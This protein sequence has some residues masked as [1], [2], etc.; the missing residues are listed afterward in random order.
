MTTDK[1]P[2]CASIRLGDV[3]I[4]GYAKGAG[5]IE[6]NLATMLV[7]LYS[8]VAS[9]P[10]ELRRALTAAAERTFNALSVD[11]DTSTSD[12]LALFATGDARPIEAA[13][14]ELG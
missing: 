9:E 12:T 6:P 1:R 11:T 5:M 7:Y 4:G 13:S 8:N 2:K 14:L 3:V 10:A